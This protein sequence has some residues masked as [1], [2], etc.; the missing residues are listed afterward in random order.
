MQLQNKSRLAYL[1]ALALLF[2][3]TE[4]ILPRF[5]PFLRLGLGNTALLL[6]LELP[7]G[8]F[9]LLALIKTLAACMMGGT[10][11]SPFFLISAAQSLVSALVMYSLFRIKG[12]W[13]SLFGIS[14]ASSAVSGITQLFLASLYLGKATMK[15]LPLMLIFSIFAGGITAFLAK[16]I[17]ISSEGDMLL[18][19]EA[20]KDS[21]KG[22]CKS[23]FKDSCKGKSKS[24]DSL[25]I[26]F[27]ILIIA[28]AIA[29]F[30]IKSLPLLTAFL[31]ISFILQFIS[32]RRIFILPH[33]FLW[34]FVILTSLFTPEG[35]ILFSLGSFSLTKG[36]LINGLEKSL[37]L[38]IT[39]ALSQTAACL[40]LPQSS[41]I[42]L[43]FSYYRKLSDR[44]RAS[45]E[46][47]ILKRLQ[48]SLM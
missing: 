39:A 25:N 41:L 13:L 2:S 19:N 9:M 40:K 35:E 47:N 43:T 8:P 46:K 36:A 33:I 14:I 16:N 29:C 4:M 20:S 24:S 32:G 12:K 10:L 18:G 6:A 45:K 22:A 5:I 21:C 23:A 1:G 15:L 7:F 26:L 28:A 30:I 34:L 42:G 11:F 44:F 31:I 27:V 48:E 37:R 3:Y 38:S 17:C